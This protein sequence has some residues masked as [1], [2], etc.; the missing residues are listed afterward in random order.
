M[1]LSPAPAGHDHAAAFA[2]V[3]ARVH[4]AEA[5]CGRA[6]SGVRVLVATK[7]WDADAA[8]AAVRAG[9]VLV[10]ESRMQELEAKGAALTAAGARIHVIGQLQRNKAAV[11][12]R[13]ADCVQTVDSLALAQRL[14]RL[15]VEAGRELDVMVQV[16][17]SGESTKAG[18]EPEDALDFAATVQ[19]LPALTVTG[20]MTIGLNSPVEAAVR[21]GYRRL[22]EIRDQAL[23]ASE[24]GAMDLREA[25]ELS[26]GMSGDL[27]WA[28][29]EGATMV[30]VGTAIMGTRT[31]PAY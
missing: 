5:S 17:V 1:E 28:I 26:M 30:R 6:G 13:W 2:D 14:S 11:A 20:F 9:A 16:N 19:A 27:E 23:I 12:V 29:A 24:R 18:I 22:R 15:C 21:A 31:P 4:V 8:V 10:G 7:T 25:W 3:K